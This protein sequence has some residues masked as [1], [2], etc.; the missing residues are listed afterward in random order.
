MFGIQWDLVFEFLKTKG[1]LNHTVSEWG[2]S[3]DASF[4]ITRGQYTNTPDVPSS[5]QDASSY[6]KNKGISVLLTTGASDRNSV[7]GIY[8]L[9]G[10]L[11][12]MTLEYTGNSTYP[13]AYRGNGYFRG[14]V[15]YPA[16]AHS[17]DS[18]T[19][20]NK[21]GGFRSTLW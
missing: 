21:I 5:W 19:A 7:L 13:C 6:T 2:N 15:V 16:Y 17:Y 18:A 11:A 20:S 10:N 8:D 12:E 4:D 3:Q 1:L 14:S 9:V